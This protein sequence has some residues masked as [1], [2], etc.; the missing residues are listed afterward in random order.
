VF[1]KDIEANLYVV[2]FRLSHA[3]PRRGAAGESVRRRPIRIDDD[4]E[5]PTDPLKFRDI[6]RYIDKL[7]EYRARPAAR[8]GDGR[9]AI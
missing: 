4:A 9:V 6:K 8:R 5:A 3:L 7:K 1:H 2:R